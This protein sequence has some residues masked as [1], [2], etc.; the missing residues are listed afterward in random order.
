MATFAALAATGGSFSSAYGGAAGETAYYNSTNTYVGVGNATTQQV[1][2]RFGV[3]QQL[4]EHT[5]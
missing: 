5:Q 4:L 2:L 3:L 1:L